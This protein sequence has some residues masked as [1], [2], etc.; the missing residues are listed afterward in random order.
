MTGKRR[1]NLIIIELIIIV[2]AVIYFI[3]A[4][5][6]VANSFKPL[7]E[8]LK[9]TFSAPAGLYLDS[10]RFVLREM[11]Y[12]RVIGNTVLIAVISVSI[13]VLI[14]SMCGYK[15]SR[16][17]NGM[18]RVLLALFT[19]SMIIPFQTIMIPLAKLTSGMG[20]NNSILGYILVYIPLLAPFAIFMYHSFVKTIPLEI[21]ES[22]RI[23]GCPPLR[24]FFQI[25]FPLLK[26]V[27]ATII[28]L[29]TLWTWN[30][31]S[32]ALLM[33]QRSSLSTIILTI[34]SFFGAH[35]MRWDYALAGLTMSAVP[36]VV[37]FIIMQK[38]IIGGIMSGAIKG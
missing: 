6:T 17:D 23:D 35:S 25:V 34:Y 37:F 32:V 1:R 19:A 26:P 22:A 36:M 9:N 12:L 11:N 5:V 21:E 14:S 13:S 4:W 10:F 15:L 29:F 24:L 20:I 31:F 30:E 33:L 28:V 7:G 3:P 16:A 8:I 2:I 18:S 38:N 27:N